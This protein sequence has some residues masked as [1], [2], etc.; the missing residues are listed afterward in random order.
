MNPA[1]VDGI[2]RII[3]LPI[4]YSNKDYTRSIQLLGEGDRG[5]LTDE[6]TYINSTANTIKFFIHENGYINTS[7]WVFWFTMGF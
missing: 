6:I 3:T 4:N 7:L 1:T 5:P 2:G